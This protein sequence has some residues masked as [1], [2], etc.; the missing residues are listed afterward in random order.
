MRFALSSGLLLVLSFVAL[1]ATA[2]TRTW[3]GGHASSANWNL[4]DNWGGAAVP[5]NGDTLIFPSGAAR[6]NNTNNIP[7]LQLAMIQFTGL[8]GGYTLRGQGVTLTNGI[9]VIEGSDNT[10]RLNSIALGGAQTFHIPLGGGLTV[11]S[12]VVLNGFNLSIAAI[13]DLT[14]RGAISGNG[15]VSKSGAGQLSLSGA[16]DNTFNGSLTIASG[17]LAM[18]KFETTSIAPPIQV[19]RI[20]VPGNLILGNGSGTVTATAQF[21]NQIANTATVT[22][23][24]NAILD[25]NDHDEAIGE[26][27]FQGGAVHTGTGVLIVNGDITAN[28]SADTA[29]LSGLL[30]LTSQR[31]IAVA[32]GADLDISARIGSV[33]LWGITKQGPGTLRLSGAN[34]YLGPT[35]IQAG[36][37]QVGHESAFGSTSSGTFA[38]NIGGLFIQNTVAVL[39][40][41]LTVSGTGGGSLTG[42]IR[43]SHNGTIA[44]NVVLSGPALIR[45]VASG[46]LTIDGVIGGAGP[47]RTRGSGTVELAGN[48]ANNFT[49]GLRAEEGMVLLSKLAGGAVSGEI[50]VGTTNSTAT[51]RHTRGSNVGGGVTVNAGSLYDLNGFDEAIL[52]LTLIGGGDV[53]TGDGVLTVT[54]D[55]VAAA[56]PDLNGS[57]STI[58]GALNV[59]TGTRNI[60]VAETGGAGGDAADLV[61]H[62]RI[63]GAAH[64]VKSGSG[65]LSLTASNSFTG[66]LTVQDG[67][68]HVAH[69]HALGSPVAS[70]SLSGDSL[71]ALSGGIDVEDE[72]LF[73]STI[74]QGNAGALRNHGTNTWTGSIILGE[75]PVIDVRTNSVL[76]LSGAIAGAGGITKIGPGILIFSGVAMNAYGG[77][78][79]VNAGTLRLERGGGPD[80][81]IPGAL[82]VGDG[83]GGSQADAVE[84]TVASQIHNLAAVTVNSSG[85]LRF[86]ADD[87]IGSLTGAGRVGLLGGATEL[88]TGENNTSTTFDGVFSGSGSLRKRGNGTFTLTATNTYTGDTIVAEGTLLVDGYQ[89]GS[90]VVVELP[91]TLAG[92]GTAGAVTVQG[93][94]A[95]GSSKGSLI[96][97]SIDFDANSHL[98]VGLNNRNSGAGYSSFHSVGSVNLTGAALDA[99]LDWAPYTGQTFKIGYYGALAGQ[100]D[101]LPDGSILVLNQIPLQLAYDEGEGNRITLTVGDLALRL[102]STR[103]E[104]GNGNGR[105]EPDECDDLFVAIENPTAGAVNVLGAYLESTDDSMA[106]T[107]SEGLYGVI[108]AGASRTNRVAFQ[109]RT[110][111]NYPCGVRARFQLVVNTLAH[112]RFAIPVAL[113]SGEPG[114]LRAYPSL[115][116]PAIIPDGGSLSSQLPVIDSFVPARVRVSVHATHPAAGQ[117]RFR[118]IHPLGP[119]VVLAANEGG[120]GDNYGGSCLFRTTFDDHAGTNIAAAA[121]PFVGTFAPE[122]SL[123]D[124]TGYSSAGVWTLLVED[125]VAGSVGRL[126]CWTLELAPAECPSGGGGC[127]SCIATVAGTINGASPTMPRFLNGSAYE[128]GCGNMDP[129]PGPNVYG[130]APFRFATH[131]FTNSGPDACVTA[132]LNVPCTNEGSG[133]RL[134]A[135]LGGFNP[136]ELC[137]NFIGYAGFSARGDLRSCSFRVPAGQRFTVVINEENEDG[138]LQGCGS[139]SLELYGLPCPQ[140]QPRLQFANDAGPDALRLHWSTAYPGFQLQ[141]KPTMG[142]PALPFTNVTAAPTVVGGHYSVTN[143]HSRTNH[144]FFRLRK[145]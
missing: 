26:L 25:I 76:N 29:V 106:V 4:R 17:T 87:T 18:N 66:S 43:L 3:T 88:A 9:T 30:S 86:L 15:N 53:E 93:T 103:V 97:E 46:H 143:M 12:N 44:T 48:L 81:S 63:S 41:P 84:V 125:T 20:A 95:P 68:L 110:S 126:E 59:H 72:T 101:G 108:P 82:V 112:G 107:R 1:S 78:T 129:C 145:P 120:L 80:R 99:S 123:A 24:E 144:G 135:Y 119:E 132:V 71:L 49:D 121:A 75:T 22:V 118:L 137:K 21:D 109:I 79:L 6:L 130:T 55:I 114:A 36:T 52:G 134:T 39:R 64:I 124:L 23:R 56:R 113:T 116:A 14:L 131:A 136:D 96:A 40:E 62:A 74:G 139:Y 5:V 100:F 77:P 111:P 98:V 47:L 122:G 89:P 11:W 31:T 13:G 115:L 104:G 58:H 85:A 70:T 19:S 38:T 45:T 127:A 142:G 94:L 28:D 2:A 91:A 133:L 35:F 105:I 117:L 128:T 10:V 34:T 50:V 90:D 73:L 57:V 67:E 141:G 102:A 51:V 37:L 92:S 138:P 33:G 27:V 65:D 7:G 83:L 60:I 140:E 42:V 61:I 8:P 69:G 32:F 54:S 16:A